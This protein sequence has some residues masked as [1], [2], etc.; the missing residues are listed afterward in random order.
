MPH[1]GDSEFDKEVALINSLESIHRQLITLKANCKELDY[2]DNKILCSSE[3]ASNRQR[4]KDE[5]QQLIESLTTLETRTAEKLNDFIEK[6]Q[7]LFADD[8]Q[9][10]I[11]GNGSI[12]NVGCFNAPCM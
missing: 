4:T 11:D 7:R 8:F 2:D 9:V 10:H 6:R 3:L 12:Q 1:N 5:Y